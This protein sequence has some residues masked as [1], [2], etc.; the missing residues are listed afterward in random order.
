M[1]SLADLLRHPDPGVVGLAPGRELVVL[2]DGQRQMA[3]ADQHVAV[4]PL[5]AGPD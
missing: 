1:A 3:A 2:L 4:E 5:Q